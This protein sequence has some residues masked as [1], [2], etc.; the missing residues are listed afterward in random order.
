MVIDYQKTEVKKLSKMYPRL[1]V[2]VL[3]LWARNSIAAGNRGELQRL[4]DDLFADRFHGGFNWFDFELKCGSWK[5]LLQYGQAPSS[6]VTEEL[7]RYL[8]FEEF[9]Q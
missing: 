5:D 7:I 2:A 6:A 8:D 4:I 9:S 3:E 1:G